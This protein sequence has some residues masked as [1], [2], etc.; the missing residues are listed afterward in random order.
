MMNSAPKEDD[1]TLEQVLE[2][3]RSAD[4]LTRVNA[5]PELGR[6]IDDQRAQRRL[7]ELLDDDVVTMQVD[8]AE[9]LV[10]FGGTAGLLT[11][12]EELGRRHNDPDVDYIAYRLYELDASG[13]F[14]VIDNTVAVRG[15]LSPAGAI[16]FEDLKRLKG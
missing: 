4:G 13:E 2:R 14:P 10:R 16:G 3:S 7:R 1:T 11:V 5:I 8:A 6:F 9:V 12:L 15:D